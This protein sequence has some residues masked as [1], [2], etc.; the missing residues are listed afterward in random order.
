MSTGNGRIF[1]YSD[2]GELFEGYVV[3]PDVS[4]GGQRPCV[5]VLHDWS[6]VN[7]G[8]HEVAERVA[9][10]G[11]VAFA[12]D[13]Y[14]KGRRGGE[15]DDNSSLMNPLVG[16]RAL[17]RQR[18]LASLRAA[19]QNPR[20]DGDRIAAVGYCFGGL[21]ALD[22][23][24]AVPAGLRGVVSVHGVL[25]PPQLGPQADIQASILLLHGWEDPFAPPAHI[26]A[27]AREFTDAKADWQVHAYGHAM[28]AFSFERAAKPEQGIA[29]DAA[30]A[31]RSWQA[32][33]NFFGEVFAGS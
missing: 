24:R 14:G 3:E 15:T 33:Q 23:A 12:A 21:C 7:S 31:R 26:E 13:V 4:L 18:L 1:E 20:V 27:F 29:Y 2:G 10:L 11:Y 19:C 6:G 17:L 8:M 5:L 22:L 32:M 30:A 9:G 28:H 25:A 16:D